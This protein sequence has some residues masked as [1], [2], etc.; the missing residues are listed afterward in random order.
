MIKYWLYIEFMIKNM[1]KDVKLYGILVLNASCKIPNEILDD[2][3]RNK[4]ILFSLLHIFSFYYLNNRK[5]IKY[6]FSKIVQIL[7]F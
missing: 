7:Y 4:F 6:F 1:C 2:K 5:L 3:L